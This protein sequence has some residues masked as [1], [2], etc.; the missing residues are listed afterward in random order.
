MSWLAQ[1]LVLVLVLAL[2]G[3][4][5]S[6]YRSGSWPCYALDLVGHVIDWLWLALV[7]VPVLIGPGQLWSRYRS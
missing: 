3:P 6:R 5:W 2:V 4:G 1:D 7:K